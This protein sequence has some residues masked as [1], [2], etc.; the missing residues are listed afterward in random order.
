VIVSG[1]AI[2]H[3]RNAAKYELYETIY[4]LL[5][6]GGIFV[7]VEHV[8]SESLLGT[9]LFNELFIDIQFERLAPDGVR[10]S[11]EQLMTDFKN[12]PDHF[13]NILLP[14]SAQCDWLKEIGFN[15][16]DCYFRC[17]E[18]AVFAGVKPS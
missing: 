2:H 4:S 16:V 1:Y 9:N 12:R 10:K 5:K 13:E 11:K 7:N 8:R 6:P 18:L 14:V 3:L 17:F 15:D